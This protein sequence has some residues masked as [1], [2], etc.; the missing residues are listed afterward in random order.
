MSTPTI[1]KMIRKICSEYRVNS[2]PDSSRA[3]NGPQVI[4][5]LDRPC[6]LIVTATDASLEVIKK[7]VEL[8]ADIL[9][10][11]HGLTW[12]HGTIPLPFIDDIEAQRTQMAIEN[13]LTIIGLHLPMDAHPILGNNAVLCNAIGANKV[14]NWF[15][16]KGSPSPLFNGFIESNDNELWPEIIELEDG[17]KSID[18]G[19]IAQVKS[20]T[21]AEIIS[22]LQESIGGE[23]TSSEKVRCFPEDRE[24]ETST[25][26]RIAICT[27]A[28][29]GSI[30]DAMESNADLLISGEGPA[31][32]AILA[33]ESGVGLI[34]GGHHATET[35]G[36]RAL[37]EWLNNESNLNNWN[38]KSLF[39]S[40]PIGL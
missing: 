6:K 32:A 5:D 37:S 19:I 3:W 24:L 35:F 4:F 7:S 13:K 31:H 15:N 33:Q 1:R 40:A 10:C 11:H 20:K 12:T 9:I 8:D 27:G 14:G 34:L 28:A 25:V 36:P 21:R 26:K 39:V 38:L 16:S 18:I 17:R 29:G 30:V 23:Q 2:I 22:I